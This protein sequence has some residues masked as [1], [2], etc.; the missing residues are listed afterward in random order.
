M[1]DLWSRITSWKSTVLGIFAPVLVY[2]A[3]THGIDYQTRAG[4][5]A[6][7]GSILVTIIQLLTKDHKKPTG[8]D[9]GSGNGISERLSE[10]WK[11]PD[12][13]K[14][15]VR[16]PHSSQSPLVDEDKLVL[17]A[18][19]AD[20]G[21]RGWISLILCFSLLMQSCAHVKPATKPSVKPSGYR[22]IKAT[23]TEVRYVD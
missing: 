8:G 23:M 17:Q 22:E 10:R 4:R 20:P 1:K 19:L 21:A 18:Y 6:W 13:D 2:F 9:S 7:A 16:S 3:Q 11:A 5:L 12:E 14:S 15:T